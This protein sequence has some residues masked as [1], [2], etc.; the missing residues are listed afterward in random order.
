MENIVKQRQQFKQNNINSTDV[1]GKVSQSRRII[2]ALLSQL[3][4]A[5]L[6][7]IEAHESYFFG[8]ESTDLK[9]QIVIHDLSFYIDVLANGSIGAAEAFLDSKWTS[10]DLTKVI[11]V[12]ARNSI[13][14]DKIERNMRWLSKLKNLF[15]RRKNINS[16]QG[17]KR[18]ILA[19]YDIGNDLYQGFLDTSMQYSSAIYNDKAQSLSQ[20]QINKMKTICERLSL[21][22]NDHVIEVGT[23]WGGLAIYMA[24]NYGCKVTTTTISDAQFDYAQKQVNELDLEDK[25]TLLKQDY[26]K[27]SGQYDKLVSIEMIE[28][29]GHEFLPTFFSTCSNLLKPSGKMLIQSITIAD[30]RY[31]QYRKGVDFIQKYIFPGGCLPSI[32]EMSRHFEK[33]TDMVIHQINDIGLH[34]ART[35]DDWKQAFEKEWEQLKQLGYNEEFKRLWLFYFSYCEGAFLERVISTHHIVARKPRYQGAEDEVVLAY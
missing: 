22:A 24:Q 10:P 26:R 27:L 8:D 1:G 9:G 28:A 19:H 32:A 21:T 17:S 23:G 14:L 35:L 15:L 20:A 30:T 31:E 7:L 25:I 12:M 16:E 5:Q 13:E 34:Y 18:N 6:E 33:S 2:F 29:V 11:Q 4:D 3:K